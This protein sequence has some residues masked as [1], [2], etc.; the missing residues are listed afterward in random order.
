MRQ[1]C[2]PDVIPA[3]DHRLKSNMADTDRESLNQWKIRFANTLRKV[4]SLFRYGAGPGEPPA[5]KSGA[6]R[7]D[8]DGKIRATIQAFGGFRMN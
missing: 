5:I 1:L 3:T 7:D 4:A 6:I 8:V 2:N